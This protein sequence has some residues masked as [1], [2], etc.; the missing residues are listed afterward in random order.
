MYLTLLSEKESKKVMP[1]LF[2]IEHPPSICFGPYVNF[3]LFYA[4]LK[5]S[6]ITIIFDEGISNDAA[7]PPESE[8]NKEPV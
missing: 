3:I 6:Q 7:V 4:S 5:L 1:T 8:M 2:M